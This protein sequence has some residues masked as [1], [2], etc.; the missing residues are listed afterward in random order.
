M[1]TLTRPTPVAPTPTISTAVSGAL[2]RFSVQ[3]YHAMIQA[4]ILLDGDPVELIEGFLV[5]HMPINPPHATIC[6][7]VAEA[8]RSII[9]KT[10]HVREEKPITL[11][12]SEP[13]PNTY[14]AVGRGLDFFQVHPVAAQVPLVIEVADSTLA[15]DRTTMARIYARAAIATYWIVNSVDRQ[16]E[17][18]TDPSGPAEPA[19]YRQRQDFALGTQVPVVLDG[20]AVG[21]LNVA[22]VLP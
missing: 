1:S 14:I 10:Y 21:R 6:F 15:A 5:T 3:Q 2:Y 8:M 18:Y 9:P 19:T 22:D 12:D 11:G 17:V 7:L 20:V 4:G 16:I 13:E